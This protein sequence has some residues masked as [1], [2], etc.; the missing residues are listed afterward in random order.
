MGLG[1]ADAD[2]N[3]AALA[4]PSADAE[5]VGAELVAVPV[6]AWVAVVTGEGLGAV[7][8]MVGESGGVLVAVAVLGRGLT[9]GGAMSRS[10]L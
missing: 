10:C 7:V 8:S 6:G 3:G 1:A 5:A 4:L 2:A 9:T